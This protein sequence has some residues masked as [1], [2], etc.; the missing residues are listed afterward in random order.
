MG[1]EIAAK[2]TDLLH[3][4]VGEAGRLDEGDEHQLVQRAAS[5][6]ARIKTPSE[7]ELLD[8]ILASYA[9]EDPIAVSHRTA[10]SDLHDFNH[11]LDV[12][13]TDDMDVTLTRAM[14]EMGLERV[15]QVNAVDYPR[16]EPGETYDPKA[17]TYRRKPVKKMPSKLLEQEI[18]DGPHD[19]I[20][21]HR[22]AIKAPGV[23]RTRPD[24]L[25]RH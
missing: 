23:H 25:A 2:L 6:L 17:K 9:D 14:H 24:M 10:A 19:D 1:R 12:I 7:E 22:D 8:A 15:A 18:L 4:I 3:D 13:Q 21:Y 20:P 11:L 16:G 5:K